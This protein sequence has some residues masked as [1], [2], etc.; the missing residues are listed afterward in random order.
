MRTTIYTRYIVDQCMPEGK[1]E[2]INS[3]YAVDFEAANKKVK[4]LKELDARLGLKHLYNIEQNIFVAKEFK[5][6]YIL[7][8]ACDLPF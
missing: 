6:E 5:R 3:F 7:H 8:E 2:S 4:E 1:Q